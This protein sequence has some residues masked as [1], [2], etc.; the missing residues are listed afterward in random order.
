M[1]FGMAGKDFG[2]GGPEHSLRVHVSAELVAVH[3]LWAADHAALAWARCLGCFVCEVVLRGG[4]Q[5]VSFLH[6]AHGRIIVLQARCSLF[7][8]V[9][10]CTLW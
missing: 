2:S 3:D 7:G 5:D 4:Q 6:V 9:L 1:G 8:C 10:F